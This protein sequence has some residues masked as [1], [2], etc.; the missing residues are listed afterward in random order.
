MN[1]R[2]AVPL[3]ALLAACDAPATPESGLASAAITS[4][5]TWSILDWSDYQNPAPLDPYALVVGRFHT[6]SLDQE[7]HATCWGDDSLGQVSNVPNGTFKAI[8]AGTWHTCGIRLNDTLE[9]WGSNDLGQLEGI[10]DGKVLDV[11]AGR[12]HTCAILD[13]GA[14]TVTCWGNDEFHAVS[15]LPAITGA[16]QITSAGNFTC[17]IGTDDLPICWGDSDYHNLDNVPTEPLAA[18]SAGFNHACGLRP[19]GSVICWGATDSLQQDGMPTTGT[20]KAIE[21][22][23]YHTCLVATDDTL[24]C[25]GNDLFGQVSTFT[26]TDPVVTVGAGGRHTCAS[27]TDGSVTCWGDISACQ[28]TTP[29]SHCVFELAQY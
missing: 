6:C 2:L 15:T 5:A 11:A 27:F 25:F 22:G 4:G 14:Q 7:G 9:C 23:Y 20:F 8:A 3:L 1:L 16:K 24:S 12:G 28:A 19:D 21:A 26:T 17:V 10:P 18:I 13:D 29:D